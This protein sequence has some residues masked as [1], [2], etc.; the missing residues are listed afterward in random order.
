MTIAKRGKPMHHGI[1][2]AIVIGF[3]V[4]VIAKL[5]MPGNDPSGF[6]ITVLIGVLGSFVGTYIGRAVGHYQEGQSAGFLMSL[7]GACTLLGLYDFI[8]RQPSDG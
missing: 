8:S 1:I 5:I 4:G 7:V 2:M 6:I 3:I